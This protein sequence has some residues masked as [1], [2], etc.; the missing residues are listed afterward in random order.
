MESNNLKNEAQLAPNL[1][2]HQAAAIHQRKIEIELESN[3]DK[4]KIALMSRQFQI[5]TRTR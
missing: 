1:K 2:D 4:E 3:Q 5:N